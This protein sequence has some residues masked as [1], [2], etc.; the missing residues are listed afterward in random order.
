MSSTGGTFSSD[1]S[2]ETISV[3]QRSILY[4]TIRLLSLSNQTTFNKHNLQSQCIKYDFIHRQSSN[5]LHPKMAKNDPTIH[6]A[7]LKLLHSIRTKC[8]KLQPFDILILPNI[9]TKPQ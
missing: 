8:I 4:I 6:E 5:S 7:L 1:S 9:L 2:N 3:S